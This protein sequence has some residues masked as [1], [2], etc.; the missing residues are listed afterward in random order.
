MAGAA[1]AGE[2]CGSGLESHPQYQ[3]ARRQMALPGGM[4]SV[5]VKAM[6][7]AQQNYP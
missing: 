3:L 5:V 7:N 2:K 4:I 6:R 1:S